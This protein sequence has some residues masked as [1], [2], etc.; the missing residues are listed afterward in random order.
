MA[1]NRRQCRGITRRT[2][3]ERWRTAADWAV[4][5]IKVLAALVA[6]CRTVGGCGLT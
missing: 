1:G 3:T 6:L 2:A 5:V 4:L